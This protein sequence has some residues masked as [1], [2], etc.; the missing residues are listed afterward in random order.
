MKKLIFA[1]TLLAPM[2]WGGTAIAQ[3]EN[4]P[5]MYA[6]A[7]YFICS[8]DGE[9]RADEIIKSSFKPHYDAAVEH[10]D[11]ASWSWLQHFV[12]GHWRR[13]L[14]ILAPDMDSILDA[15][16]AL[17]EIIEEAGVVFSGAVKLNYAY[18]DFDAASKPYSNL[19][20]KRLP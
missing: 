16:G 15:S 3:E 2:L 9:S 19:P 20:T 7:T 1:A 8:P 14:V 5:V 6:Y 4:A 13:V 10:G 11:I 18:E 17:G 12:G